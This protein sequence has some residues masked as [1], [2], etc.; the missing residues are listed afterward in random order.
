MSDLLRVVERARDNPLL[1]EEYL[2]REHLGDGGRDPTAPD[3]G[4][5][6]ALGAAAARRPRR[7]ASRAGARAAAPSV[8][9]C[10]SRRSRSAARRSWPPPT[11]RSRGGCRS[12]RRPCRS[13]SGSGRAR[14]PPRSCPGPAGS[15]RRP[16]RTAAARAGAGRRRA[17]RTRRRG[18]SAPRSSGVETIAP[19]AHA[20]DGLS[21]LGSRPAAWPG[22]DQVPVDEGPRHPHGAR[23]ARLPQPERPEDAPAQQ[24][25]V[26][27]SGD[28]LGDER[29]DDVVGVR[30]AVA[31]AGP[32][33]QSLVRDPR[34]DPGRRD[35]RPGVRPE[36]PHE[37]LGLRVVREPAGV[38]EH[39]A[40]R[41][42]PPRRGEVGPPARD[43]VVE[44]QPPVAHELQGD[45]APEGLRDARDAHV[46]RRARRAAGAH[47][48]HARGQHGARPG[49]AA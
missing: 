12:G 1:A 9:G 33:V 17:G 2:A 39:L 40:D 31:R 11:A 4:R 18:R 15:R 32:E 49:G 35:E 22:L 34:D 48:G 6:R 37:A 24:A 44:A 3:G 45:R 13:A 21:E 14:G 10:S 42:A 36:V 46:V 25:P 20:P 43:R 7:P 29:D 27:A 26:G 19:D 38:I 5:R 8:P 16:R 28:A 47:V 30:V 41:H 23:Q